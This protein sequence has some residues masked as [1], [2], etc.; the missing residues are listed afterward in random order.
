LPLR[1]GMDSFFPP[2][3]WTVISVPG[4]T[5]DDDIRV[6]M[7][8]DGCVN[9]RSGRTIT[10]QGLELRC[11]V[12]VIK[13]TKPMTKSPPPVRHRSKFMFQVICRV[14]AKVKVI[15]QVIAKVKVIIQV[16]AKVVE[17]VV[18]VAE[19]GLVD[20]VTG[21]GRQGRWPWLALQGQGAAATVGP[22]GRP[23]CHRRQ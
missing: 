21:G 11:L 2:T 13:L 16:I 15:S 10:H 8:Y 20:V 12:L 9:A 23:R 19:H 4:L 1:R 6:R 7:N 3:M 22:A 17:V 5:V 14:M 18:G